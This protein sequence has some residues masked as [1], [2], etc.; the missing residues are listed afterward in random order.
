MHKAFLDL[1]VSGVKRGDRVSIYMPMIVELS[2]AMLACARIG[3]IHSI[4]VSIGSYVLCL[5]GVTISYYQYYYCKTATNVKCSNNFC[6]L[7]DS[8]PIPWLNESST[9]SAVC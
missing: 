1:L 2:I 4:V 5:S 9:Q 3:A 6:S 8:P 7:L